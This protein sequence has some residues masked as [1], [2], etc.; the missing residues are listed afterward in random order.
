MLELRNPWGTKSGQNWDTTFEV[1][2]ATLLADDDWVEFD[3]AGATS[4]LPNP[5]T[6]AEYLSNISAYDSLVGA[7]QISDAAAAVAANLDALN[8]N[9]HITS[10]TL[11]GSGVPVLNLTAAQAS[12]DSVALGKI[13]NSAYEVNVS[14]AHTYYIDAGP[15]VT[16]TDTSATFKLSS[17][18]DAV[19]TGSNN[20][21]ISTGGATYTVNGNDEVISAAGGDTITLSASSTGDQITGAGVDT[22]VLPNSYSNYTIKQIT[23]GVTVTNTSTDSSNTLTNIA[24]IE[25]SDITLVFDLHSA[26]DT[27]VYELYQAAYDRTPDNA[28]FRYWANVGD[29]NHLSALTLADAFL[30]APEF[31]QDYGSN[32]TN[33]HYVTELYTNVLGRAPDAGGLSY[34]IGQAN[35][36]QPRDQL[37]V[38]FRRAPRT[39]IGS[40]LISLTATGRRLNPARLLYLPT[41]AIATGRRGARRGVK[42][43]RRIKGATISKMVWNGPAPARRAVST[44][45]RTPASKPA[46]HLAR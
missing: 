19:V 2:L 4:A 38:D 29:A 24:Q 37:L 11:T 36:G 15:L 20:T 8:A 5:A 34:W 12:N 42:W 31:T 3:N 46:A 39:K 23:G 16:L 6:T 40:R 22:V 33:T 32:P 26:E 17:G 43:A 14:G 44:V 35:A 25:F 1:S 30:T 28:G 7:I 45:V 9:S 41:G 18:A 21:F 13:A 27:L 10:I